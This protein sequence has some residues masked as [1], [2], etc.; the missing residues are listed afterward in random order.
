MVGLIGEIALSIYVNSKEEF[1]AYIM[2]TLGHPVITVNVTE[3]QVNH[4]IDDALKR[5]FEFHNEGAYR[6]YL[7]KQIDQ[8]D[9]ENGYL[10]LP[11]KV[12]SV[13]HV[14]PD[15]GMFSQMGT[16]NL[17]VLSFMQ[18]TGASIYGQGTN[19]G[20]MVSSSSF[21]SNG[22]SSMTYGGMTN[23]IIANQYM[24]TIKNTVNGYHQFQFNRYQRR[25]LIDDKSL[26][27]KA[28]ERVLVEVFMEVDENE[29][30]VWENIWLRDY[31]VAL[32]QRQWGY[33][34]IKL[35]NV[36]LANGVTLDGQSI[37]QEANQR[38][39]S[40]DEELINKWSEPLGILVG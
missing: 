26:S 37:L 20:G 8:E 24:N 21:L 12:M 35:G 27:L 4:R 39:S 33:N 11:E 28:G 3:E 19:Y 14:Y 2:Q 9:V 25:L 10:T 29:V 23:W 13:L 32:V 15:D 6:Y 36:Q 18:A 16:E 38:I 7:V 17:A 22:L 1:V 40:L 30:P 5:F 31:A 34:L